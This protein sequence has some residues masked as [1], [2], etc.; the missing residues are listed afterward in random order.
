MIVSTSVALSFPGVESITP[1]GTAIV[2]V[3]SNVPVAAGSTVPETVNVAD[4]P[5]ARSIVPSIDPVPDAAGQVAPTLGV[6]VQ[7]T[8]VRPGGKCPPRT[9]R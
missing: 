9:R 1:A 8:S 2:A 4:E 6:Q 7:L 3:F 5:A